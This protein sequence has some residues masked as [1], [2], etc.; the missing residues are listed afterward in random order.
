MNRS[1]DLLVEIGTE[2]LPPKA[3]K[4]L[5][6]AFADGM[7]KGLGDARLDHDGITPFASP[8]RLAVIVRQLATA[9]GD[10]EINQKG[11]PVSIAF[12]DDGGSTKAAMAFARKCGVEVDALGREK[13]D[14]GEWLS[15]KGV[16]SGSPT[17]DLLPGIVQSALDSLPIA[18][19][20]RWGDREEEFVRPVHWL[21]MLHGEAPVPGSVLGIES[22][23]TTRGHRYHAPDPITL[24]AAG[25]YERTLLDKGFVVAD[26]A[27]RREMIVNA[28]TK[29][30]NDAGGSA[31]CDEALFD[32][33]AALT[34]WPVPLTGSFDEEFLA[35]PREVIVETLT[36]HQ[37]Y[38]PVAGD[39]GALKP[40]F[41]TLANLESKQPE[42][43]REGNERVIRPRLADAKFFW[44]T[45]QQTPLGER[46]ESL[47]HVVNDALMVIFFSLS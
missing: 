25:D 8:R 44:E 45:D 19:R 47:K 14:A 27:A 3:L 12:D 35:L 21:V 29:A 28:V 26:F 13:T 37:R 7:E 34:E 30:A 2:E 9:Q 36:S 33:V 41:I 42:R 1:D 11:P 6:T 5:M 20:M 4:T 22:G 38:F 40:A 17:A 39:D 15:Y 32:E 16:E 46:T 43:V 18:R 24:K 23:L 10:R 31:V